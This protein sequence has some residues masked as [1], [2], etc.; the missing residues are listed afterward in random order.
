MG[1][2][3]FAWTRA[4]SLCTAVA[5]LGAGCVWLYG[6]AVELPK[7]TA[8]AV[9]RPA[10][11]SRAIMRANQVEL[12]LLSWGPELQA[13][14]ATLGP[15]LET[16]QTDAL[17]A[18]IRRTYAAQRLFDR[19]ATSIASR[20]DPDAAREI[21]AFYESWLG[22][23]VLRAQAS[24]RDVRTLE[25][26]KEWS[27][28]FDVRAY[29]PGRVA[30][31]RRLDRA[32]LTS[33]T[34]VWLNRALLDAGLGALGEGVSSAAADPIRA[35]RARTAAEEA[36]LYPVAEEQVLRWNLYAYA[37]ISDA[38]LE[39]YAAFAESTPAQWWVVTSVRGYRVTLSGAG[40]DLFQALR[41]RNTF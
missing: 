41:P 35:L 3:A 24:R 10:I 25:R 33:Q 34:A 5:W 18:A 38:D 6:P 14:L 40:E 4:A 1:S 31:L 8:T 28:H 15:Q 22:Q 9:E 2:P 21:F 16:S 19:M 30:T 39:R 32:L 26:F 7:D 13:A 11:G 29:S 23:R 36:A 20:W 17:N 37:W 27:E 12:E